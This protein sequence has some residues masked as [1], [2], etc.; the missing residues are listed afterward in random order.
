[1][2]GPS[3]SVSVLDLPLVTCCP[4]GGATIGDD[5][6][7]AVNELRNGDGGTDPRN[8][9]LM[10][11]LV[12]LLP[13]LAS[14][15]LLVARRTDGVAR[16]TWLALLPA[17]D[18]PALD[19]WEP[20]PVLSITCHP[21]SI[22]HP[23]GCACLYASS[24]FTLDWT[25]G[26]SGTHTTFSPL[27][28]ELELCVECDD[29]RIAVASEGLVMDSVTLP[30][31]RPPRRSCCDADLFLVGFCFALPLPAA[32]R[33]PVFG[34]VC[35]ASCLWLIYC[36]SCGHHLELYPVQG[37]SDY[38]LTPVLD[39]LLSIHRPWPSSSHARCS[40]SASW[41]SVLHLAH[42]DSVRV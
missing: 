37:D 4:L 31:L 13:L 39:L 29:M 32:F 27:S 25:S 10:S 7:S 42:I 22:R 26:V 36:P 28:G 38:R 17:P 15:T 14:L 3:S 9:T 23:Q 2:D 16:L 19:C 1:M 8:Y 40:L 24:T 33:A 20:C 30:F 12:S 35:P 18:E 41:W 21:I 34:I 11:A 6:S 5:G